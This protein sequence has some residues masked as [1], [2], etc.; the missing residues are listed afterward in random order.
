MKQLFILNIIFILSAKVYS[1][2]IPDKTLLETM[3]QN[4]TLIVE[5]VSIGEYDFKCGSRRNN[6]L[7]LYY[8]NAQLKA[9]VLRDGKK[10]TS[11][12]KPNDFKFLVA[13]EKES[14]KYDDPNKVCKYSDNYCYV[15]NEEFKFRII[16][17]SCKWNGFS[18][19]TKR[20]FGFAFPR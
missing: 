6:T 20:L 10:V 9:E 13:I 4:D 15:L 18:K 3:T 1:Q 12:V 16:D 17:Q 14:H 2:N 11:N 7:K 19:I 5:Y 8:Q